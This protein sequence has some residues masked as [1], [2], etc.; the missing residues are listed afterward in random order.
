MCVRDCWHGKRGEKM[1]KEL[2]PK[3]YD[4]LI[5]AL[6]T[7]AILTGEKVGISRFDEVIISGFAVF[8]V[9]KIEK[10]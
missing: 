2:Q 9:K 7:I 4:E 6:K 5:S 3:Q 8:K 10:K 1:T